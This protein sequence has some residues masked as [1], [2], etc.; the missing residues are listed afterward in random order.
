MIMMIVVINIISA[1]FPVKWDDS[2]VNF[3]KN[4]RPIKTASDV[5]VRQ[6]IYQGSLNV[7]KN[8]EKDLIEPF[9]RLKY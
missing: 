6:K 5:Q 2:C 7:W 3:Y 9:K 4:K 8:Y 1:V